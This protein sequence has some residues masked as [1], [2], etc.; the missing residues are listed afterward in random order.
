MR[1]GIDIRKIIMWC[2]KKPEVDKWYLEPG[3]VD[4]K[5]ANIVKAYEFDPK[6]TTIECNSD[7]S[8]A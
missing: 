1:E 7:Y 2:Y 6:E 5:L 4:S 3:T 8:R